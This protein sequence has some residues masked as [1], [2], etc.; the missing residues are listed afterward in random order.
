MSVRNIV[1]V[2]VNGMKSRKFNFSGKFFFKFHRKL[3]FEVDTQDSQN[4]TNLVREDPRE[5][6]LN[7]ER[8]RAYFTAGSG[9][10]RFCSAVPGSAVQ[11]LRSPRSY[12]TLAAQ[13]RPG[14][15]L[16]GFTVKEV[17]K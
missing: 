7:I 3:R 1:V 13:I 12:A 9:M 6:F 5:V 2:R 15:S 10:R 8:P 4:F 14:D 16:H 17:H 11:N